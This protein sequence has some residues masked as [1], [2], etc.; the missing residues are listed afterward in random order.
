MA[1]MSGIKAEPGNKTCACGTSPAGR[2]DHLPIGGDMENRGRLQKRS[3][4]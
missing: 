1:A 4:G 3:S 2:I